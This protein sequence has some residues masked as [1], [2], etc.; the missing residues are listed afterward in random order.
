MTIVID[1]SLAVKWYL[2]ETDSRLAR[3]ILAQHFGEIL[4]PTLFGIEVTATLVREANANKRHTAVMN[5]A[6]N[7]L[8]ALISDGSIQTMPQRP[9]HLLNA[10]NLAIDLGHPLKDC[11]YLALAMELG[12]DL[13]TCDA[14][15]AAKAKE[16]WDQVRVL[17]NA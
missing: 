12:C 16:V 15:F 10:A 14:K 1:A 7:R 11:V 6:I 13:V 17:G 8:V 3:N 5:D 2:L 4:V 9:A